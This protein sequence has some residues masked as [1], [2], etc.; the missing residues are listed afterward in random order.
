MSDTRAEFKLRAKHKRHDS[1]AK[2]VKS[3]VG[4][5]KS[6]AVLYE[7]ELAPL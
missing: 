2:E 6:S 1:L 4:L 3:L 5:L 7:P